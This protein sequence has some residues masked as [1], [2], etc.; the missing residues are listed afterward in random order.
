[1]AIA[2]TCN[3]AGAC[4]GGATGFIGGAT[5]IT[6]ATGFPGTC[7]GAMGGC[8]FSWLFMMFT[9]GCALWNRGYV[10]IELG[11]RWSILLPSLPIFI[12]TLTF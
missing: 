7:G 2:G 1:M 10:V 5:G 8:L 6:G 11:C 4:N 3:G 12:C 9:G